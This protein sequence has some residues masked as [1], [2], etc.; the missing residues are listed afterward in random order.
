MKPRAGHFNLGRN[1]AFQ[2]GFRGLLFKQFYP[3]PG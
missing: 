3:R 1:V 2:A